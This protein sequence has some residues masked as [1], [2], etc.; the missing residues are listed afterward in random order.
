MEDSGLS[1]HFIG[2]VIKKAYSMNGAYQWLHRIF[3][4]AL[5]I[6]F[7]YYTIHQEFYGVQLLYMLIIA[8]LAFYFSTISAPFIFLCE[9][10]IIVEKTPPGVV[11]HRFIFWRNP[12]Y[13][14][15]PYISFGGF[16]QD[17]SGIKVFAN[18]LPKF[19]EVDGQIVEVALTAQ[20]HDALGDNLIIPC[21]A[22]LLALRD[23]NA[24]LKY[25]NDYNETH[26]HQRPGLVQVFVKRLK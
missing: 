20:E 8:C 4:I 18:A 7:A 11:G 13:Y 10:G 3:T 21:D 6:L 5:G 24:I 2:G 23:C 19:E 17:Y 22:H 12:Q 1:N 26:K 14:Y 9:K 16:A 15:V 25:A